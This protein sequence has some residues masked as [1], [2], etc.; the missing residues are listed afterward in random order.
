M[1]NANKE[2]TKKHDHSL[3]NILKA[4]IFSLVMLAPIFSITVRCG[5]VMFNKNAYKSYYGETINQEIETEV[6]Y[7]AL[8][9]NKNYV[10]H[11]PLTS[12]K[13]SSTLH[14]NMYVSNMVNL[15][16]FN[17]DYD[18][19]NVRII[20]F[21][22]DNVYNTFFFQDINGTNLFQLGLNNAT[23][24]FS[25]NFEGY[26][27]DFDSGFEYAN[28]FY[29]V[30]FNKYSYLDNA[31]TYGISNLKNESVFNWTQNTAIY[32][33]INAMCTGL[34]IT[35]N[36]ISIMLTYWALMTAIYI[37][38]DIVIVLFTKLTHLLN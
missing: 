2:I 34:G 29:T 1:R 17:N 37:I 6:N 28:Y 35:E 11:N 26:Y 21:Y 19:S 23:M 15:N 13:P 27:Q 8:V 24:K 7:N 10:F 5:Y 32:I 31:F 25:F 14:T 16:G 4:A 33:P 36:A 38:F 12:D 9:G 20:R 18:L 22:L 3:T 30:S